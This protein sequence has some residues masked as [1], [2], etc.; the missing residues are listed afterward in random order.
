MRN[1]PDKFQL[2]SFP[3]MG[4]NEVTGGHETARR[5]PAISIQKF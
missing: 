5:F 4:A 3:G 2:S 1:N